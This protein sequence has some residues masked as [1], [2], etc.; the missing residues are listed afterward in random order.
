MPNILNGRW[1]V[2]RIGNNP[3]N[4]PLNSSQTAVHACLAYNPSNDK[5]KVLYFRAANLEH[6]QIHPNS[7]TQ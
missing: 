1:E 3:N 6:P 7:Q 2:V 5:W 4:A